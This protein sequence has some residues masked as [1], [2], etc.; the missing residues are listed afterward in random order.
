MK[1]NILEKD[2]VRTFGDLKIGDIFAIEHV[3]MK[4]APNRTTESEYNCVS[5]NEE[6]G[7]LYHISNSAKVTLLV[8]TNTLELKEA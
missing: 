8:P 7:I 1:I 6:A 3:Y 2:K 5:F 4:V